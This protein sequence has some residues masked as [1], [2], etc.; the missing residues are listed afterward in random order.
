MLVSGDLVLRKAVQ[1]AY[2]LPELP[3]E[4]AVEALGERWRPHR[5]LA[6]GYLFSLMAPAASAAASGA[7]AA[8]T[9]NA[10]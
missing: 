1:R 9:F 3:S 4:R 5:S 10:P 2:N 6:A 8:T 7:A